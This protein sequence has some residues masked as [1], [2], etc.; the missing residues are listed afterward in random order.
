M[1]LRDSINDEEIYNPY[2]RI[3]FP[4][5]EESVTINSITFGDTGNDGLI[6]PEEV[7]LD[8]EK[9]SKLYRVAAAVTRQRPMG[10]KR[11]MY[12]GDIINETTLGYLEQE[13]F[14]RLMSQRKD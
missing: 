6:F 7:A 14:D 1:S 5:G 11:V 9:R 12:G 2:I 8:I 4:S 13:D 3:Y 10:H